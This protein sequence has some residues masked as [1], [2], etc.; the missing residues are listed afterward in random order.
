M[1]A[2]SLYRRSLK[3]KEDAWGLAHEST[4]L[5]LNSLALLLL[6]T[7]RH[8]EAEQLYRRAVESRE[9]ILGADHP[10]TVASQGSLT[11]LLHCLG[12][13]SESVS[14]RK[15]SSQGSEEK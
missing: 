14:A 2:E 6:R 9:A 3:G 10:S 7:H 11:W 8:E 12:R 5:T 13:G 4:I 1:G 15:T